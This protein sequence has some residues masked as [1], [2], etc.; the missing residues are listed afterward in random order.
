MNLPS[1]PTDNIFKF[2]AISGLAFI[3]I[4]GFYILEK[5]LSL[6]Q[7]RIELNIKIAENK[8][9]IEQ[10]EK[11][12]KE[13]NEDFNSFC[14]K[15]KIE[16]KNEN[17]YFRIEYY[18]DPT[19]VQRIEK[20]WSIFKSKNHDLKEIFDKGF[21][22]E[23]ALSKHLKIQAYKE[24]IYSDLIVFFIILIVISFG[25]TIYGL[26]K[27]YEIDK[28]INLLRQF[29]LKKTGF[30]YKY[31]Q[32]C[33][34]LLETDS[35]LP[36]ITQYLVQKYCT[37]CYDYNQKKFTEPDLT[38]KLFKDKM[39]KELEEKGFGRVYIFLFFFQLASF[40]RWQIHF[41]RTKPKKPSYDVA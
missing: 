21:S 31:C 17:G 12:K 4:S 39:K 20:M 7:Q 28:Q 33:G 36:E 6:D 23:L 1:L 13:L 37:I 15:N 10:I 34:V 5:A 30:R 16:C 22:E 29:E 19:Q 24:K 3:L 8:Y 25:F 2:F 26:E 38:F 14:Q 11:K 35:D 9:S 18:N 40:E 32:S 27:W 41:T